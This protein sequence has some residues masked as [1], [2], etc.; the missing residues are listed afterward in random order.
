MQQLPASR[1]SR[2][3]TVKASAKQMYTVDSLPPSS[4]VDFLRQYLAPTCLLQV[5]IDRILL[6]LLKVKFT[7]QISKMNHQMLDEVVGNCIRKQKP[8]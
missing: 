3:Q 2:P 6:R 5:F 1:S 8:L 4:C 7:I